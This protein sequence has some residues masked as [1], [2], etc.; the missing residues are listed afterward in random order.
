MPGDRSA[1]PGHF[2]EVVRGQT[3]D[4]GA[5]EVPDATDDTGISEQ[6]VDLAVF[7]VC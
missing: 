5:E 1:V 4:A 2:A 6:V 3:D 7:Q